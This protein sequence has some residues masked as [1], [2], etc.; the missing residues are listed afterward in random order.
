MKYII[1]IFGILII[2][3]CSF[4]NKTG[5]WKDASS[6]PLEIKNKKSINENISNN[7]YENLFTKNKIY[8]EEKNTPLNTVLNLD[9]PINFDD[10]LEEYGN[11]SNNVSNF[12]YEGNKLLVSKSR[13]L[14]K[15]SL[16]NKIIFY[17]NNLI[18]HDHK[19]KIFIYSPDLKKKIFEFDFYKK[20]FKRFQKDIYIAV[21]KNTLYA[22]DNLGY[23]YAINLRSMS[24]I[25]AKN[26]G[27]PFRSNITIADDQIFLA[28]QDNE[29][30]SINTKTGDKNWQFSTSLTF[31]K[32]Y[33]VN[34]FVVDKINKNIFFLNTSGELYS[35]NYVSNNVNWLINFK[36]S[37]SKD[38]TDATLFLSQ[39]IILKN[40]NLIISTNKAILSY[41][42]LNASKIWNFTSN[43]N[44]KPILT[45]NFTYIFSKN[46]LLIC[47]DNL[48]GKV[49]WSKNIY[50]DLDGKKIKKKIGVLSDLKIANS[51]INLFSTNGY[52][53]SFNHKN[54]NLEYMKKISKNGINSKIIY[55]KSNM[56]LIDGANKLLRFN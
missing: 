19:G 18:S 21:N 29:I 46:D 11:S 26:Y 3:S 27:I 1:T 23:I 24:L 56:F 42:S 20:K 32:S 10:W 15:L 41:N 28:N 51:Q 36:N 22:A 54:G 39:P 53:L 6:V 12:L 47:L 4:D 33:Y 49:I 37:S 45:T 9:A 30:F 34:N 2:T 5:I 43:T 40:N 50:K 31:L 8:N 38:A 44:L 16:N 17:K 35:I 52:L 55:L 14:S 25:W 48:N 7:K 13:R